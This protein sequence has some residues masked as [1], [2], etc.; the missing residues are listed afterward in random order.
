MRYIFPYPNGT[1]EWVQIPSMHIEGSGDDIRSIPDHFD[2]I[3]IKAGRGEREVVHIHVNKDVERKPYITMDNQEKLKTK[4]QYRSRGGVLITS[5]EQ[6][7][8]LLK[9]LIEAGQ[10][11]GFIG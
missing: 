1:H 8:E 3:R 11:A 5:G 6:F 7:A 10:K 9:T 2:T 4:D